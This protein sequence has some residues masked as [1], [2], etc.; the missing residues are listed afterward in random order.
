MADFFSIGLL[1]KTLFQPFRQISADETGE[2]GGLEGALIAFFDRT[3]SRVIGFIV[4][5]FIIVAGIITLSL[6]LVFG[7]LLA[8]LW[9]CVP[10]LPVIGIIVSSMGVVF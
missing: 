6:Q 9:P 10:A 2:K 8:V 4:R 3:L 1:L 7:L 5:T